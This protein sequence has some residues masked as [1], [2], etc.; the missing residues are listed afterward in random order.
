MPHLVGAVD[1]EAFRAARLVV[2]TGLHAMSWSR[3]QAEDYMRAHTTMPDDLI[4]NEVDRYLNT[5]G[6]ALAYKVGQ[7][8]ILALRE[9]ARAAL[10]ARFDLRAFHDVV[11]GTGAVSLTVLD[12]VVRA[13]IAASP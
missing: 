2:D 9:E 5:P 10:G 7:L 6:Q 8:E 3:T 4:R 12:E 11:L 1:L 13:W